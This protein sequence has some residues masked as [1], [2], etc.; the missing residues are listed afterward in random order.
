MI[1]RRNNLSHARFLFVTPKTIDKRAVVRNRLR[2]RAREWTR[3]HL[4][5]DTLPLDIALLFKKAAQNAPRTVLYE[6]LTRTF[7]RIL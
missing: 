5:I 6:E 7:S 1:V 4:S 3:V 2:R